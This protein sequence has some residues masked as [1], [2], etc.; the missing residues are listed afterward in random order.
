MILIRALVVVSAIPSAAGPRRSTGLADV[1]KEALRPDGFRFLKPVCSHVL[2][3]R[4]RCFRCFS[5]ASGGAV[6]GGPRRRRPEPLLQ[7]DL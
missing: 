5:A 2:A 3:V 6:A 7:L 1:D 4:W